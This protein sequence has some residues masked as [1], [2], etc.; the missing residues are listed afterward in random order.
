MMSSDEEAEVQRGQFTG[1]GSHSSQVAE[2]GL[3]LMLLLLL[4][5]L[6]LRLGQGLAMPY[7][8]IEVGIL[9]PGFRCV[10]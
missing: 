3:E 4:L 10:F 8:F 1:P 2:L 9:T 5:L 6:L 7:L